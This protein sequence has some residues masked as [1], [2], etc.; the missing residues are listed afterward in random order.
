MTLP[1]FA[2]QRRA[3]VLTVIAMLVAFGVFKYLTMSRRADPAFTIRTAQVVTSWPGVRAERVERLVTAPIEEKISELAEVDY[4]WS[5]T[6]TGLSIIYVEL[7]DDLPTKLIQ[8]TWERVRGKV[9]GVEI[10][11][12]DRNA[13]KIEPRIRTARVERQHFVQCRH[14]LRRVVLVKQQ[15][16]F[17]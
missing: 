17:R 4:V 12:A 10:K 2:M 3:I 9:G 11:T 8:Q 6:T 1:R 7:P 16:C 5:E 13:A 15:L 14:A